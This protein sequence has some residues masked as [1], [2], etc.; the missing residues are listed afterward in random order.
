M[1]DCVASVAGPW[2]TA[3][4]W[5]GGTVP[6]DG[7]SVE[8]ANGIVVTYDDN[9]G[10]LGKV[11]TT[12][13]NGIVLDNASSGLVFSTTV[14]TYL[15]LKTGTNISGTGYVNLGSGAINSATAIP[16][17]TAV[18]S[19]LALTAVATDTHVHVDNGTGF[20]V[21]GTIYIVDGT[22]QTANRE[23]RTI[24]TI[25]ATTQLNF[26]GGITNTY[27]IPGAGYVTQQSQPGA[28][29]DFHGATSTAAITATGVHTINGVVPTTPAAHPA[30]T[31]LHADAAI[32]DGYVD[33]EDT[34]FTLIAGDQVAISAPTAGAD[35]ASNLYAVTKVETVASRPR[36]HIYPVL[37]TTARK[38][39]HAG[40][41][42]NDYVARTLR[43]ILIQ[44]AAYSATA[45]MPVQTGATFAGFRLVNAIPMLY[46]NLCTF[47]GCSVTGTTPV[48][49]S[50]VS[51]SDSVYDT[52][53]Y[54]TATGSIIKGDTTVGNHY[55]SGCFSLMAPYMFQYESYSTH[56]NPVMTCSA[57]ARAMESTTYAVTL[58]NPIGRYTNYTLV[59][60]CSGTIT[61]T[62]ARTLGGTN[63][64]T[65]T[66]GGGPARIYNS[67]LAST[68]TVALYTYLSRN[69]TSNT[70][71]YN[72]SING[73]PYEK[74][75]WGRGGTA[76]VPPATNAP[77]PYATT[78]ME[79]LVDGTYVNTPLF[80]DTMFYVPQNKT[81]TV[82]VP[83]YATADEG[84]TAAVWIIDPA[85]D[86]LFYQQFNGVTTSFTPSTPTAATTGV[87]GTVL[88][89]SAMPT[90][91]ST[92]HNVSITVPAQTT[93]KNLICRVIFMGTTINK[94]GYAYLKSM[95][96]TF[97]KKKIVYL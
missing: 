68:N 84:M 75:L 10:P 62:G 91:D 87:V 11:W 74:Y 63:D 33:L 90:P 61:I 56:V 64:I 95:E 40:A 69:I 55:T 93:A 52:V 5:T 30:Y 85:N 22:G 70:V 27:T 46:P 45:V 79:F 26:S 41:E 18:T 12:G 77:P 39:G 9:H 58:I 15:M 7:Q 53:L 16:A 34:D 50:G 31:M 35:T 20:V 83:M 54:N 76:M 94:K 97:S 88:A 29:L 6:T 86:P 42:N 1:A 96:N 47:K 37:A 43:P 66:L 78:A 92:W 23:T 60:L 13:I 65:G 19:T 81:L 32:S 14:P 17:A 36:I 8:I 21:G 80:W 48:L 67:T 82:N 4:T 2:T 73:T 71:A 38:G 57:T 51:Y 24:T 3:G 44:R 28:T 89:I 25:T 72:T 49:V 59:S